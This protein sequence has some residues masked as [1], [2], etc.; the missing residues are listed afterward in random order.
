M[1]L[2]LS[3]EC[4]VIML[5]TKPGP[6][7]LICKTILLSKFVTKSLISTFSNCRNAF[8]TPPNRKDE[9]LTWSLINWGG[10]ASVFSKQR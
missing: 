10:F 3:L 9:F 4:I 7:L 5:V 2:K 8:I 1:V 6:I